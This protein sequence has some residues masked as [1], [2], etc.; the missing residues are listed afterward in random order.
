MDGDELFRFVRRRG[1]EQLSGEDRKEA[2]IPG[3][4]TL[5]IHNK[6]SVSCEENSE[7]NRWQRDRWDQPICR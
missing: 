3:L 4:I 2:F 7:S 6:G 1:G 5:V